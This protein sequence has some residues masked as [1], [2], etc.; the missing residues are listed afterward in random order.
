MH[1]RLYSVDVFRG[2]TVA[3]MITVNNPGSWSAVFPPLLHAPWHGCTPTDLIF[4]FFLFIMGF[5]VH[6]AY[7][8]KRSAG[9]TPPLIRKLLQRAALIFAFG[10]LLSLFPK[11]DFASVRIPGVL[12]RI[13]LVFLACSFSYFLLSVVQQA[14][15]AALLL[16]G[17]YLLMTVVPVPGIGD[18]SL[19]KETNL[20]AWLDRLLLDG[21]L[22]AQSKTWDP[23]GLLSTLPAIATGLLGLLA[24]QFFSAG[25]TVE[26]QTIFL[27]MAGS[28]LAVA[29]LAW[30]LIFPINK[31]L[32]TSSYVLYTA[33]LAM[34]CFGFCHWLIEGLQVRT[35]SA[36]FQWYGVN[37]IFVFVASGLLAKILLRIKW[38]AGEN[39]Y[40]LWKWLYET[41]YAAWFPEKIASLFFAL[42]LVAGFGLLL[43]WMHRKNWILKV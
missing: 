34:L 24:G 31:A 33:G 40:S 41:L 23:E 39:S 26:R 2:L 32:W 9:L 10:L 21:H 3:A 15:L 12:Q 8:K 20:A 7:E 11:F 25:K 22:W 18:P 29:G 4:P 36:P 27:F 6:L 19:E 16:V 1:N 38:S 30:G 37:A 17:Y 13:S 42:T 35:W 5:S 43:R 28:T 14:R